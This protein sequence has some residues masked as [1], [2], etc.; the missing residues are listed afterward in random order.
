MKTLSLIFLYLALTTTTMAD[1]V[2][3]NVNGSIG[4]IT[5]LSTEDYAEVEIAAIGQTYIVKNNSSVLTSLLMAK[6][7]SL[8]LDSIYHNGQGELTGVV[9]Q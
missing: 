2:K 4:A 1:T 6:G 8:Q 7:N 5:I 3:V 9:F